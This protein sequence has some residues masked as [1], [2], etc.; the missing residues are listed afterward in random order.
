[1]L[2]RVYRCSTQKVTPSTQKVRKKE[3]CVSYTLPQLQ[4]KHTVPTGHY[5]TNKYCATAGNYHGVHVLS[6]GSKKCSYCK[7]SKPKKAKGYHGNKPSNLHE[8][9]GAEWVGRGLLGFEVVW[10]RLSLCDW[11][12]GPVSSARVACLSGVAWLCNCG[13]KSGH[14]PAQQNRLRSDIY[15]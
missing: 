15:S 3:K 7:R 1:M 4:T 10:V 12:V 8:G 13:Y 6:A 11:S 5:H 2:K 9:V 14:R